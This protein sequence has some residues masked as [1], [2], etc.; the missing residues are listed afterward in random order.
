[1]TEHTGTTTDTAAVFDLLRERATALA[2]S[3]SVEL[4][5]N[6]ALPHSMRDADFVPSAR[7]NL[8]LFFRY[9]ID[10]VEPTVVDTQPLIDRA[11]TLV[12]DGMPVAEVW[13]NYRAGTA[14]FW[15]ALVPLVEDADYRLIPQVSLRLT[16]YI[17]LIM[18]RIAGALVE[19]ARQP[20]WDLLE[21]QHELADALLAG[22]DPG[23]WALDPET[24]VPP[25]FLIAA[26]R[27][28]DP[29]PGTLTQLRSRLAHLPG[30]LLHRDSGGWTAL[31]P[32]AADGGDP[33]RVLSAALALPEN[34]PH[35][36]YWIGV[37]AATS[38]AAVPAAYAEAQVVAEVARSL[39]LPEVLCRQQDMMFEY[40]IATTG[41]TRMTLAAVLAPLDDQPMLIQTLEAF[42][43]NEFNHNAVARALFIHRN[44]VTYRLARIADLTG[45]DPL[46]ATGISTLMAA[47][48]A[49]RLKP[50]AARG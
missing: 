9:L 29:T 42:I 32:M 34:A 37:A 5:A 39:E 41:S 10:G 18:G 49:R 44:T 12:H 20:R 2:A 26:V 50:A 1:M 47:R 45:Y 31:V 43:D 3:F 14:F 6:G 17:G 16:D 35:P 23:S 40:A 38:H 25:A 4:P 27:L 21:R 19:D 33:V 8:E 48:T 36:R 30:T 11:M 13:H 22:R 24:T 28:G 15:S 46:L 7:V